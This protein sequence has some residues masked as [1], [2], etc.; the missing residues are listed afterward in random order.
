MKVKSKV[1][2]KWDQL[3]LVPNPKVYEGQHEAKC[4]CSLC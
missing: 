3:Q 4:H 2:W 1:V